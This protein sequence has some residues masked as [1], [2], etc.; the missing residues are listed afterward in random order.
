MERNCQSS[1][2]T[3]FEN[4]H[5]M[6]RIKLSI[7]IPVYN[8]ERYIEKCIVSVENQNIEHLDYEIILVNDGTKDNSV[9]I[10]EQMQAVYPNIKLINKQNGG[11]SSS[12][13]A[14]L[15]KASG[16]YIW[17]IDSDDYIDTNVLSAI[18]E[19]AY[20]ENLDFLGFGHKEIFEKTGKQVIFNNHLC[21]R[22]I[23]N[24]E[25]LQQHDIH[26]SSCY[27]IAKRSIF[28]ENKL[29]F[30][31]GIFHE[32]YEFMLRFYE[33][34][35]RINFIDISPYNYILKEEGSITSN[36]NYNHYFK[37]LNSWITIIQKLS[38]QY[39]HSTSTNEYSTL[40]QQWI[41]VFKYHALSAL[42]ML[43]LRY[44]DKIKY[45]QTFKQQGCF[46]SG[47][48]IALNFRRH[49]IYQVY[50]RPILFR[51][52]LSVLYI[53]QQIIK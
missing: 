34:C 24:I 21:I 5:T 32:D 12:R 43:P 40:A 35:E 26:I 9:A 11:L 18:L 37:R 52:V 27:H 14:G 48:P 25:Y 42:I 50:Q 44:S 2:N 39:G 41:N 49:L 51:I 8:V 16:D 36:K 23:N 38:Y 15:Q 3:L 19:K 1:I 7:I 53:K 10:I 30:T 6:N 47:R 33:Y 29:L 17:F 4:M 13:N 22:P 28:I 45:Y 20:N 31:E 46:P